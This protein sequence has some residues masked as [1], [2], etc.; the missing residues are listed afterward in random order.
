MSFEAKLDKVDSYDKSWLLKMFIWG[1]PR[2]Q[3]VLVCQERSETLS[4]AYQLARDAA[5]AVQMA[6]RPRGD[7]R[8][9]TQQGEHFKVS[10]P[11][12]R[13][14][15]CVCWEGNGSRPEAAV[16]S[17]RPWCW[18]S[19]KILYKTNDAQKLQRGFRLRG[20]GQSG[21]PS[22]PPPVP[23]VNQP[24]PRQQGGSG[25]RGR[26]QGN[27]KT[28][29]VTVLVTTVDQGKAGPSGQEAALQ[30]AGKEPVLSCVSGR[31]TDEHSLWLIRS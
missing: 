15:W 4:T 9:R 27:Q 3:A 25:L 6:R 14:P 16:R 20:R 13:D 28:S 24:Y 10:Y 30:A 22:A 12:G 26:R 23:G 1:L 19:I 2:D 8:R 7:A 29:R 17:M 21:I 18:G 5:L 11:R 31:K